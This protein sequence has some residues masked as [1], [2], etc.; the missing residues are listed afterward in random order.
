MNKIDVIKNNKKYFKLGLTLLIVIIL[1][2]IFFRSSEKLN[3]TVTFT[4]IKSILSPFIYGVLIAYILNPVLKG[5]E[6]KIINKVSFIN[7]RPSL[8]RSVSITL[9]YIFLF[10]FLFCVIGYILPEI[11]E[12]TQNIITFL[13]EFDINKF[14]LDFHGIITI[15][16]EILYELKKYLSVLVS[17]LINIPN[18]VGTLVLNTVDI[19]SS[20]LN[21]ILGVVISIYILSDKENL[22]FQT[23]KITYVISNKN[24]AERII[25]ICY[26]SNKTFEKYFVGKIIDSTIIGIIFFAGAYVL[27]APFAA[28]LS[29]IIG[30][31][32]MIPYFGPFIGGIPVVLI[33]LISDISN[34]L[35]S[36]WIAIF[37][38]ALQQFDGIILGPKI[39]GNSIGLKPLSII[40]SIIIG[41][42]LFGVLGMFFGVPVFAVIMSL[43][44]KYI[45]NKYEQKR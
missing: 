42:A 10:G 8:K 34:P 38:F 14:S 45:D 37:I 39:L 30:V 43:F 16:E 26:E 20:F 44:T 18:I 28:F 23:K 11:I 2:I 25:A 24:I 32:N 31:T 12:N 5:L 1:S 7:K 27:S 21:F 15:P 22:G 9:T 41:G 6:D 3:L 29:L 35:K 17:T 40:F 33:T 4:N 19:A 13:K 36:L